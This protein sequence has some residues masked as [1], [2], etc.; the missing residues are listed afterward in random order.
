MKFSFITMETQDSK[1]RACLLRERV[2][3]KKHERERNIYAVW[4]LTLL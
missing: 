4:Q 2:L 1:S 3:S